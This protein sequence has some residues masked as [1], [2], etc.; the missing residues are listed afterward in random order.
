MLVL[1]VKYYH[2]LPWSNAKSNTLT[3]TYCSLPQ[4]YLL[5][6][7]NPYKTNWNRLHDD[8]MEAFQYMNVELD[9]ILQGVQC[10]WKILVAAPSTTF[11]ASPRLLGYS[12]WQS[13][14]FYQEKNILHWCNIMPRP[15]RP[16]LVQGWSDFHVMYECYLYFF[17]VPISSQR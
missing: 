12:W 15:P 14:P 13:T 2:R 5:R 16:H 6:Q 17:I 11:Q 10:P 7:C 4:L 1:Y 9:L 8:S 3:S